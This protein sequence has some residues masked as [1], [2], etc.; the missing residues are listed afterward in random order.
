MHIGLSRDSCEALA[1]YRCGVEQH[2][3]GIQTRAREVISSWNDKSAPAVYIFE[4]LKP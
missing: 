4:I 2:R 3:F 1:Y